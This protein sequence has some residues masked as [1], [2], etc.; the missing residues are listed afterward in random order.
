M[1]AVGIFRGFPGLGRVVSGIE[2]LKQLNQ[3]FKLDAVIFTYLQGFEF[4]HLYNFQCKNI[5]NIKDISSIGIIPVSASGENIINYIEDYKPDFVLIDGEPLLV[6]TI[7]LR[8]PN[9]LV[10]VLLNPFDVENPNNQLS[11]QLFFNDCYSK[12]DIS[13]VHGLW[14]VQKPKMYQKKYYSIN[15]ILRKEIQELELNVNSNRIACVLGGGTVNSNEYFFENTISIAKQVVE[16][17]KTQSQL[18]FDIFCGCEDVFSRVQPLINGNNNIQIH[19]HLHKSTDIYKST[20]AVISRAGRNSI[21]EL[22]YL[23][24]PSLLISTNCDIRGAEQE[25]NINF[26]KKYSPNI[27]GVNLKSDHLTFIGQFNSLIT[28]DIE[29]IKWSS[30]NNELIEI[31]KKELSCI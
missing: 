28:R 23:N 1:K 22:L 31:I 6:S 8:F 16:L 27:I 15:T 10:I 13:I 9:L 26:A 24:L 20:K 19:R 21:S 2:I 4:S 25:A 5:D 29:S 11:S 30:G 17:S 14:D 3:E 7:K 18:Y 12:A